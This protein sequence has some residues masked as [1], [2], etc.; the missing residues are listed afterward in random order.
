MF[1]VEVNLDADLAS[2]SFDADVSKSFMAE[3]PVQAEVVGE[4]PHNGEMAEEWMATHR[5]AVAETK[6]A[7]ASPSLHDKG[8]WTWARVD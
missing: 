3:S 2:E 8:M 5:D 4:L 1:N 6:A 7:S